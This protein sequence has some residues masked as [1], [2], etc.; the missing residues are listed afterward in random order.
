MQAAILNHFKEPLEL[1]QVEIPQPG[2]DDVLVKLITCGVCH[3]DLHLIK[4]GKIEPRFIEGSLSLSCFS[5]QSGK[6]FNDFFHV[7]PVMKVLVK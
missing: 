4:G 3:T 6:S 5:Y 1:K 2:P 7:Y